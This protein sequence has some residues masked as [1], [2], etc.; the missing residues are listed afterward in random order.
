MLLTS[1][2]AQVFADLNLLEDETLILIDDCVTA[3]QIAN[4]ER[5]TR[6]THDREWEVRAISR[7]GDKAAAG[8]RAN[9]WLKSSVLRLSGRPNIKRVAALCCAILGAEISEAAVKRARTQEELLD[10]RGIPF[11]MSI[12]AEQARKSIAIQNP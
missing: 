9:A 2:A 8:S 4:G 11:G 7:R 5:K 1:K 3:R 6:A 10:R 12:V